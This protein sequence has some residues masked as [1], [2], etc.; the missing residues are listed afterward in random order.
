M[1]QHLFPI[2]I[3]NK[4]NHLITNRAEN[5]FDFLVEV[6]YFSDDPVQKLFFKV[7]QRN[8]YFAYPKNVLLGKLMDNKEDIL[9]SE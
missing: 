9:I 2:M 1:H 8:G 5:Y 3:S 4:V 6:K 7:F